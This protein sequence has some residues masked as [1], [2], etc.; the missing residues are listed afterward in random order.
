MIVRS[1]INWDA[2]NINLHLKIKLFNACVKSVL[3]YG[4][5]TWFVT[6]NTTQKLY[7]SKLYPI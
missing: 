4:C 1:K 2:S 7:R 3:L 6:N 5:E